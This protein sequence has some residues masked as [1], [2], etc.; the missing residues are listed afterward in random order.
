V[1]CWVASEK[2]VGFFLLFYLYDFQLAK[3]FGRSFWLS[4]PDNRT[5]SKYLE[6]QSV[7]L[8]LED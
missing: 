7:L 3:G 1:E 5:L 8:S 4:W 2:I 6:G